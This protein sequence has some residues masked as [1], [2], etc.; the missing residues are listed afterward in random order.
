MALAKSGQWNLTYAFIKDNTDYGI[1]Y[2]SR[3]QNS[4]VEA[5]RFK[6]LAGIDLSKLSFQLVNNSDSTVTLAVSSTFVLEDGTTNLVYTFT[7]TG[8]T[9]NALTV[10]YGIA[11]SADSSD[12]TGATPGTGKTITFAA[13]ESTATLTIDPAADTTIEAD[14]TVALTLVAGS[15]Y[16][17]GTTTSITGTISNDDSLG[18]TYT[19]IPSSSTL[20]EGTELTITVTTTNVPV[21]TILYG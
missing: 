17:V 13:G 18:S 10:N 4:S 12:Y 1:F 21:G 9:T 14:E 6:S 15:G 20:N 2:D 3:Y 16:T 8:P 5:E 11:G 19:I 7:R